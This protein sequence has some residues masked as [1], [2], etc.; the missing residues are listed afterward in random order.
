MS[1]HSTR[2]SLVLVAAG[3][4]ALSACTAAAPEPEPAP[5]PAATSALPK[6]SDQERLAAT[7]LTE[8][9]GTAFGLDRV[10]GPISVIESEN[11]KYALITQC[12]E[13]L[14]TDADIVRAEQATW[15]SEDY[16]LDELT[17]QYHGV[18]GADAVTD[19]KSAQGCRADVGTGKI[20]QVDLPP[21]PGVDASAAYCIV[22]EYGIYHCFVLESRGDLAAAAEITHHVITRQSDRESTGQLVQ[23]VA[24]SLASG[25]QR[26][27]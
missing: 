1:D 21:A 27:S 4:L 10:T 3:V 11:R 20:D 15:R 9:E 8:D 16:S 26:G 23:L 13:P 14:G 18:T 24:L 6:P 17:V 22:G 25:L 5:A 12:T 2:R 7:I 19:A